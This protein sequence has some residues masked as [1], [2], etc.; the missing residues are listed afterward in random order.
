M[1]KETLKQAARWSMSSFA[2]QKKNKRKEDFVERMNEC[3]KYK[4]CFMIS[5]AISQSQ[6][7]KKENVSEG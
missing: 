7:G 5:M 3:L 1:V 4:M 6:L 2:S